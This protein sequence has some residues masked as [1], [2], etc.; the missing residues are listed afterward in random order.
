[1]ASKKRQNLTKISVI[2][3]CFFSLFAC[4]SAA[5]AW[6]YGG[7]TVGSSQVVTPD[8]HDVHANFF[9]YKFT[10]DYDDTATD[11]DDI[12]GEKL[13]LRSFKLNT[14]DTIFTQQNQYTP[15]LVRIHLYGNDIPTPA[16]NSSETFTIEV[17]R[18]TAM[19]DPNPVVEGDITTY[20]FISSAA[21]FAGTV[22][23]NTTY[24]SY[25]TGS[26][27]DNITNI[28]TMMNG[29]V[30]YFRNASNNI[31]PVTFVTSNP[32]G[33]LE[34][35]S[36]NITY[37]EVNVVDGVNH[38]IVFVLIDYNETLLGKFIDNDSQS[39]SSENILGQNDVSLNN[40]LNTLKVNIGD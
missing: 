28:S 38:L 7:K 21:Q 26:N 20:R 34:K 16:A 19:V 23:S 17:S 36:I 25:I 32:V 33:K 2:F 18:N 8:S 5:L 13:N 4:M 10:K 9:V 37:N 14:Y 30:S 6:F 1:M 22:L 11:E 27:L 40:D 15:A 24:S 12:T 3:M 29:V 35:I 31:T 39:F